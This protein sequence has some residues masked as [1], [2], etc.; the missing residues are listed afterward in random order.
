MASVLPS[1]TR[2]GNNNKRVHFDVSIDW[3]EEDRRSCR[4]LDSRRRTRERKRMALE[5]KDQLREA[6]LDILRDGQYEN[7]I[8]E[9]CRKPR[10]GI[11][12]RSIVVGV[13]ARGDDTAREGEN[14]D[15]RLR[16]LLHEFRGA[17][18]ATAA[19]L[20]ANE[21][22]SLDLLKGLK[23]FIDQ[24]GNV[25]PSTVVTSGSD[26][27]NANTPERR[28]AKRQRCD[29]KQTRENLQ[30]NVSRMVGGPIEFVPENNRIEQGEH[31]D[32]QT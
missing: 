26:S 7:E 30:K 14:E 29:D 32:E 20:D 19:N 3:K 24:F 17:D 12:A 27:S 18:K 11:I 2:E 4:G 16:R 1:C 10:S 13:I 23:S 15:E 9:L 31:D 5:Q 28:A 25:L 21:K 8:L 22:E 6:I